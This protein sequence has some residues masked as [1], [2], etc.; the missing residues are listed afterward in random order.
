ML[1]TI[2]HNIRIEVRQLWEMPNSV[3]SQFCTFRLQYSF[4]RISTA[5]RDMSTNLGTL[6]STP[7]STYAANE[8]HDIRLVLR[9][10]WYGLR[11]AYFQFCIFKYEYSS[12]H[13][14]AAITVM[15]IIRCDF[16]SR[17]AAKYVGRHRVF[18]T[19]SLS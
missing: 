13:I 8:E 18:A 17:H 11:P 10:L 4:E 7:C 15:L 5:I 12:E 14:C 1:T 2:E 3:Y 19:S 16:H 9:Q 6:Y